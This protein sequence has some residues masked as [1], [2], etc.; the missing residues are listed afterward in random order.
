M[1]KQSHIA[2]N[3]S[4]RAGSRNDL[5]HLVLFLILGLARYSKGY[6]KVV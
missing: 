4:L 2:V 3:Q 6:V 1:R 5:E